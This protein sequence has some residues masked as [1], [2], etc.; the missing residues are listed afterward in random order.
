MTITKEIYTE[1]QR[2]IDMAWS[3]P[4]SDEAAL[5]REL[6]PEGKPSVELFLQRVSSRALEELERPA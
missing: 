6:F 3:C 1:M 2:A 4:T 5:Q